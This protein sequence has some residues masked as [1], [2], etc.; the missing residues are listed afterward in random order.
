MGLGFQN[1]PKALLYFFPKFPKKTPYV[2]LIFLICCFCYPTWDWLGE[3]GTLTS[4][5][6]P[7][8]VLPEYPPRDHHAYFD[9]YA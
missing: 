5:A 6:S 9:T 1:F 2:G 4:G 8:P 3:N 7:S